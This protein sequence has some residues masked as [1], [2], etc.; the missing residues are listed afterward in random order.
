[1][2]ASVIFNNRVFAQ[3]NGVNTIENKKELDMSAGEQLIDMIYIDDVISAY[4]SMINLL[5]KD[6]R[7]TY[8]GKYFAVSS[9]NPIKLKELAC[10]FEEVTGKKLK[11]NW[12][13]KPYRDREIMIP[14][15]KGEKIPN[16][17]PII[18]IREGIKRIL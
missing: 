3:V 13:K 8:K 4:I 12:G 15:N 11:I 7:F 6:D 16:W 1:M 17:E 14:W 5:E 10:I 18:D 2:T 9:G